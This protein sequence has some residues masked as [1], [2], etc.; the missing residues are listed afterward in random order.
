MNST[1]TVIVSLFLT[2]LVGN[3]KA[4]FEGVLELVPPGCDQVGQCKLKYPLR[5]TDSAK[6]VW[7]AKAELNTDGATI[8]GVF[9]PFVGSPFDP[10]F[11]KAAVIHDHYCDRHVRPWK[12]TH[13]VFY[14]GLIANGVSQAKAKTMYFAVF[15][16]GP[17][18]IKLI[19]GIKCGPNCVNEFKSTSGVAGVYSRRADYSAADIMP[20]IQSVAKLLELNPASLSLEELEN[21]ARKIRP[22]DFFYKHEET[23][24]ASLLGITQ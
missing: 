7:E 9:Q 6:L 20:S 13:R 16:G 19:P 10:A 22:T 1:I 5:F 12:Q 21:L 17:K 14:E 18:W 2:L 11:I 3:V 15:L 4:Q 24:D 8:P 23:I